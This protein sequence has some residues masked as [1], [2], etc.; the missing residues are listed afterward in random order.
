M[1]PKPHRFNCRKTYLLH[2]RNNTTALPEEATQ[3]LLQL[4]NTNHR[5]HMK[6]PSQCYGNDEYND[7][8]WYL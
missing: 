8:W 3:P 5:N 1:H 7:T 4:L 2:R 6:H